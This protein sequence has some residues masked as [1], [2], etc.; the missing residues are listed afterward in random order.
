M[1]FLQRMKETLGGIKIVGDISALQVLTILLSVGLTLLTVQLTSL[2]SDTSAL[3]EAL[4]DANFD[5]GRIQG[6]I[7]GMERNLEITTECIE[8]SARI[9]GYLDALLFSTGLE[10]E[11]QVK[12]IIEGLRLP[13]SDD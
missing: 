3:S 4:M 6:R 10:S 11:E 7:E 5:A 13:T 2:S 8:T 1:K 12:K 9:E